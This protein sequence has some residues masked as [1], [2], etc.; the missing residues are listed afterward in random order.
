MSVPDIP[1]RTPASCLEALAKVVFAAVVAN[2]EVM[3]ALAR[4]HGSFGSYL[5]LN[6]S[7]Q[8]LI[9]DLT[10]DFH[11][12]NHADAMTCLRLLTRGDDEYQVDL[13]MAS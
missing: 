11:H 12:V 6:D 7:T 5:R 3:M 1:S 4:E 10:Q 13:C 9:A 2:A 8:E